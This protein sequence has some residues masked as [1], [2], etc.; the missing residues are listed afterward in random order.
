MLRSL[1]LRRGTIFTKGHITIM[2]VAS[3]LTCKNAVPRNK[4]TKRHVTIMGSPERPVLNKTK[5]LRMASGSNMRMLV[6]CV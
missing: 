1:I 6:M 3:G 2:R 4:I 5:N